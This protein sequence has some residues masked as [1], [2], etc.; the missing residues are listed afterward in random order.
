MNLLIEHV[1]T[2]SGGRFFIRKNDIDLA[3][4]TWVSNDTIMVIDHTE[5]SDELKGQGIGKKLIL[6]GIEYA[7]EHDLKIEPL[8]SYAYHVIHRNPEYH[9]IL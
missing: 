2:P 9:D 6:K 3:E 7:R 5:V 1:S 4:M 8:C